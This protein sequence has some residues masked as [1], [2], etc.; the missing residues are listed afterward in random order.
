MLLRSVLSAGQFSNLQQPTV[1]YLGSY[2]QTTSTTIN[3]GT[4]SATRSIVAIITGYYA[5]NTPAISNLRINDTLCSRV[6]SSQVNTYTGFVAIGAL[7]LPNGTTT[8]LSFTVSY[9]G[10][11]I[12]VFSIKG[13]IPINF[14]AATNTGTPTGTVFSHTLTTTS[15]VNKSLIFTGISSYAGGPTNATSSLP[16]TL[17]VEYGGYVLG[18]AY[19]SVSTNVNP[20]NISWTAPVGKNWSILGHTVSSLAIGF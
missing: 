18:S 9:T 2:T 5:S 16:N 3:T 8:N 1:Q 20:Y 10:V 13:K 19:T 14:S 11:N 4:P 7:S 6:S 15:P 17:I 12:A